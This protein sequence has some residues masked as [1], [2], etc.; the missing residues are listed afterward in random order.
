MVNRLTLKTLSN[1]LDNLS[2]RVVELERTLEATIDSA[3]AKLKGMT[4]G[5]RE[6]NTPSGGST[7]FVNSELRRQMIEEAAYYRAARR[8]FID[9]DPQQDWL[10][11][12]R[13]VDARLRG[14]DATGGS[15]HK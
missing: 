5:A 9:G 8:G 2:S 1:E 13:E 11:A 12:E 14:R 10:E 15:G 3:L 6:D 4:Q 7:G